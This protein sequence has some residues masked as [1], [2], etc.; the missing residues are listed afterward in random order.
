MRS[1]EEDTKIIIAASSRVMRSVLLHQLEFL[2]CLKAEARNFG[3]LESLI[4][5]IVPDILFVQADI[6]GSD[7][8]R[9][10]EELRVQKHQGKLYIIVFSSHIDLKAACLK[11]GANA[12][13]EFPVPQDALVETLSI[14][15][16]H[17]KHIL[18]VDDSKVIHSYL[19]E[20]LKDEPYDFHHA[21]DG[22]QG[23][24][25]FE[26]HAPDLVITDV[27]MPEMSGY[28]LCAWMKGH[29]RLGRTPVIISSTKSKGFEIDHGF[30]VGADDYLVKPVDPD[31]FRSKIHLLLANE[32]KDTRE[33]ILVIDDSLVILNMLSNALTTQGFHVVTA[34]D[35]E[36]GFQLAQAV[37]PSLIISDLEKP[38]WNGRDLTRELRSLPSFH[39]CPIIL[40]T[41]RDSQVEKAKARKA[42]VTEFV[43]K[44]FTQDRILVL[45]E[46]LLKEAKLAEEK[47]KLK[48]ENQLIHKRLEIASE[49]KLRLAAE[50]AHKINNPLNY[51]QQSL[52]VIHSGMRQ[53]ETSLDLLLGPRPS[54]DPDVK[55]FQDSFE[56]LFQD[57]RSAHEIGSTGLTGAAKSVAEIRA[58]S[59]IDGYTST[60]T[61]L[62]N[63]FETTLLMM[64]EKFPS[65]YIERLHLQGSG[66]DQ[67]ELLTHVTSFCE[68]LELLF[69]SAL[70]SS[71][72]TLHVSY[73]RI[74]P[75]SLKILIRGALSLD[76]LQL[77]PIR[78]RLQDT[79][80]HLHYDFQLGVLDGV[81]YCSLFGVANTLVPSAS[82]QEI[83]KG[84]AS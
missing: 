48:H 52:D 14:A 32:L 68:V 45:V 46:R 61:T 26:R 1:Y 11:A 72:D 30:D 38:N 47:D 67:L 53:L 21:Y 34:S 12:F 41:A 16:R 33:T 76:P 18:I 42:G 62:Q 79:A 13:L 65:S 22:H 54:P 31:E 60:R 73:E 81:F 55:Q 36:E 10:L 75:Q 69:S 56:K 71:R 44:P 6:L 70:Q 20:I 7:L 77:A 58:L 83:N 66:R 51:I 49:S 64:R 3:E 8:K 2:P 57:L 29:A 84:A 35:C 37:L 59:G 80:E 28:D 50:L 27:E 43:S 9:A 4:H 39:Y 23:K 63:L 25:L 19:T 15:Q 5:S 78:S 17:K 24:V 40:L 82:S 74:T